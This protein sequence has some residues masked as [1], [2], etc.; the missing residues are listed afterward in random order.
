MPATLISFPPSPTS[1][2]IPSVIEDTENELSLTLAALILG[3]VGWGGLIGLI[4][5]IIPSTGPRWFFFVLWLMAVTGTAIP[6]VRYLNRRFGHALAPANVVLRQA[7]WI[8]FF[9][10]T[11][12]WLQIGRTLSVYTVLLL[13]AGL[14]GI[15]WFLRIRERSRWT[16]DTTD[17]SA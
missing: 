14:G 6:F 3:I 5:F 8:G 2:I 15:E 4:L 9:G 13:A 17:E 10:A 12:A 1:Y 7:T 16:P 11:C